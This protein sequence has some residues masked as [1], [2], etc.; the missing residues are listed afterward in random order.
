M[1]LMRPVIWAVCLMLNST[2]DNAKIWPLIHFERLLKANC[3]WTSVM[4]LLKS[5]SILMLPLGPHLHRPL[6]LSPPYNMLHSVL[7]YI[8]HDFKPIQTWC[9]QPSLAILL[10]NWRSAAC[11]LGG[12]KALIIF[13][14]F[15]SWNHSSSPTNHLHEHRVSLEHPPPVVSSTAKQGL[16]L[17]A[18]DYRTCST[19][20]RH[21]GAFEWN[22]HILKLK[23]NYL[24][25]W[26]A[27]GMVAE[28][29][30]LYGTQS[31][32]PLKPR[33]PKLQKTNPV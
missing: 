28:W 21:R 30:L 23:Q 3:S 12:G 31:K 7:L 14:F 24:A 20:S 19:V 25:A 15:M 29:W 5:Y 26:C 16:R 4:I 17:N 13:Y 1:C 33:Y 2:E 8:T 11:W 6:S 22:N 9:V 18:K 32:G 27:S 10:D